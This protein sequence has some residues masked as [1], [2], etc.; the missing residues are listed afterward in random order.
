MGVTYDKLLGELLLHTHTQDDIEGGVHYPEVDYYADLPV[1]AAVGDIY[2][3]RY[4]SGSYILFNKKLAGFYR[5]NGLSWDYLGELAISADEV[6]YTPSTP[7]HWGGSIGM[8][9][10]TAFDYLANLIAT[11]VIYKDASLKGSGVLLDPLGIDKA[12]TGVIT[13]DVNNKI[14]QIVLSD[15]ENGDKTIDITYSGDLIDYIEETQGADYKK[16]TLTRDVNNY[17]TGFNTVFV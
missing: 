9:V 17:I 12:G 11:W 1:G 4:P 2:L 3:V 6:D 14:T 10:N 7:S 5:W 15:L 16:I 8:F 13:R